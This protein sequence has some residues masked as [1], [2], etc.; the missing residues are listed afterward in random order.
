MKNPLIAQRV[1]LCKNPDQTIGVRSRL[2]HETSGTHEW[3]VL[4]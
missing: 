4:V 2:R 1:F 3:G